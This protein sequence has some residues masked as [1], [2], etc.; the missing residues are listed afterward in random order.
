MSQTVA[1][2]VCEQYNEYKEFMATKG[3]D[4]DKCKGDAIKVGSFHIGFIAWLEARD[5]SYLYPHFK[6]S[7]HAKD[8]K[9][10]S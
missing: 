9:M 10:G 4:I 2:M 6:N 3:L 1:A 7:Q 8:V 5:K